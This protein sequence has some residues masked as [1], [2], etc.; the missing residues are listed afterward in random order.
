[1]KNVL[2][3]LTL[4]FLPPV[5]VEAAGASVSV[6]GFTVAL[7]LIQSLTTQENKCEGTPRIKN[8]PQCK[9]CE[10]FVV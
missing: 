2:N 3:A 9:M 1:M 5:E 6:S 7:S 4:P 10:Q 8:S